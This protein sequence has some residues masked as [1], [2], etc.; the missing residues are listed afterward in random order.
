MM[1]QLSMFALAAAAVGFGAAA[2]FA[3]EAAKD[4][5]AADFKISGPFT[6]EKLTIYLIRGPSAEGPVPLTLSE[7]LAAKLF[8]V[9]ETGNVQELA[10]ENLSDQPVFL[11]SGD[12][13]KGGQ[14]DRVLTVSVLVPAKSGRMPVSAYCVEAHRWAAR[15]TE[16][17]RTFDSSEKSMPSKRAKIAM[18][19]RPAAPASGPGTPRDPRRAGLGGRG[20][21]QQEVWSSVAEAQQKLSANLGAPVAAAASA[22]S[23]QLSLENEKLAATKAAYLAALSP[24]DKDG[25]DVI[26]FAF[27]IN[28]QINSADVYPSHGL[29]AKM[30]GKLI[31]AAAT[32]AISEKA[33]GEARAAP[34][35]EAVLAFLARA[36]SGAAEERKLDAANTR[37]VHQN[38]AAVVNETKQADGRVLHRSYVAF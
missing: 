5:P 27:A 28:G 1:F 8:K 3:Q 4:V 17:V 20:E 35:P 13:V 37:V 2:S 38:E 12:I 22:S 16:S 10:I 18:M 33:A 6:H 31:D 14:Q 23:L 30:W 7:A 19:A 11:Q 29:F 25:A 9:H 26:G 24:K 36:V 34:A 21:G 32:E 15:G